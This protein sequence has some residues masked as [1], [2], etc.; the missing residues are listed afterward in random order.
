[1]IDGAIAIESS[2]LHS[3]DGQRVQ[4]VA[5]VVVRHLSQFHEGQARDAA[6]ERSFRA[7]FAATQ[8]AS[9]SLKFFGRRLVV[10]EELMLPDHQAVA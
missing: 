1:M 5:R 6:N 4:R 10:S 9:F 7:P 8:C 3:I 2:F